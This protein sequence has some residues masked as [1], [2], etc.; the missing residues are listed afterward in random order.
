MMP[1]E[2][3]RIT[4]DEYTEIN[5]DD[6]A[7]NV[8]LEIQ[9]STSEDNAAKAQE[10]SFM[11]QTLGVSMDPMMRNMIMAEVARLH[12][13]PALEKQ[14]REWKPQVDPSAEQVKQLQ[15]EK[16]Y[17]ENEELKA[18]I[19]DRYAR[20]GENEIDSELKRMKAQAEAAKARKISSEAD[21]LD[22]DFLE[23][24]SGIGHQR[25]MEKKD[26]DRLA[27]LDMEAFKSINRPKGK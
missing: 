19:A 3:I 14:L 2:I 4:N 12:K 1:Q 25:E 5:R 7:G 26:F 9:V 8:D 22:L 24:E 23:K 17:L 15:M 27:T 11:L 10:L 13:M 6:L 18:K 16:L 21:K 20:A